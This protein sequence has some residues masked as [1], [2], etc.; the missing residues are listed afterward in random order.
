[1]VYRNRMRLF[2]LTREIE[3]LQTKQDD[4]NTNINFISGQLGNVLIAS[5]ITRCQ[6]LSAMLDSSMHLLTE[7]TS[8][9]DKAQRLKRLYKSCK[10]FTPKLISIIEI[11]DIDLESNSPKLNTSPE[12]VTYHESDSPKS[13]VSYPGLNT[14]FPQSNKVITQ[15]IDI[16]TPVARKI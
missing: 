15:P 11:S 14:L 8:A 7:I 5:D 13:N 4:I 3:Q 16:K 12:N 10:Y 2:Y 1:M 9:L 6:T